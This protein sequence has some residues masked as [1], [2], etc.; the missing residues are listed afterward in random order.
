MQTYLFYDLETTGLNYAF[1][2]VLQFAAIRTDPD[3][4]EFERHE[5]RVRLRP[6]VIPSP[7]A[8]IAHGISI[9][10]SMS[11]TCE[12]EATQKIHALLNEPNTIS[13]GYNTLGFDDEFLR[14]AFY[15]NLLPPYTHQ[16]ANNCGRMD[17]LPMVTM[18]WLYKKDILNWPRIDDKISLRLEH[19]SEA[20]QLTD[21]AAHDALSDVEASVELARRLSREREMWDYL[22]NYFHKES[23]ITHKQRLPALSDSLPE[24]FR[25][26]LL[27][28]SDFGSK[29]NYQVPV[30][31]VGDSIPYTNQTI[32]LRLD[33]PSLR[34]TVEDNI[35]ETTWVIR[36]KY[37]QLGLIIPPFERFLV[38]I[39][40]ERW[41]TVEEN[42]KW[43]QS[44]P[45]LLQKIVTY[46]RE[47]AYPDQP[48]TD[49]D[50]LLYQIGFPSYQDE[51]LCRRF[52]K[53]G[54]DE[55]AKHAEE[56]E[57]EVLRELARRVVFRNYSDLLPDAFKAECENYMRKVNP[58]SDEEII[59]DYR[60]EHRMTP[61]TCL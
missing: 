19:L 28:D 30:V 4:H 29:Q 52:H 48:D 13:L 42:K 54:L 58:T 26:G 21:G 9:T 8:M 23:D 37:G 41:Q 17:L 60:G 5:I 43:L 49:P 51:M 39:D 32:W 12:F 7:G 1:D 16:Y 35:R 24:V 20:N 44:H 31:F 36:K 46:Y 14:F 53:A 38:K 61:Q 50:A 47:F 57:G 15:R 10:D 22:S 25:F 18:Y 59:V 40:D 33:L 56:F 45:E 34:E 27:I 6:D 2:Q 3:F 11:G 55:K